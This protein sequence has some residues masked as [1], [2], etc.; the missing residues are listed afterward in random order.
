M[1]KSNNQPRPWRGVFFNGP[2]SHRNHEGDE[3][4]TWLVYVGDEDAEPTGKVYTFYNYRWARDGAHAIAN[5]RR[6]ELIDQATP[7]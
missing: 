6:L 2:Q 3:I 7:A 4:P 1:T 5:D